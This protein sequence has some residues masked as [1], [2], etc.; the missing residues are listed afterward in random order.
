MAKSLDEI[1]KEKFESLEALRL[2]QSEGQV[3]KIPANLNPKY[4]INEHDK[5][6]VHFRRVLRTNNPRLQT[7]EEHE[8]VQQ[9]GPTFF[10]ANKNNIS[11][12]YFETEIIHDPR[13]KEKK[14]EE[15]SYSFEAP[16][17]DSKKKQ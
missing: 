2:E 11:A 3:K 14:G 7:Y 4:E 15:K 13:A 9:F 10:E 6:M 16:E 5:H 8:D 17:K 12:G 1:K